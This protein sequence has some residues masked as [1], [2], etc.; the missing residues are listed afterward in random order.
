MNKRFQ[1]SHKWTFAVLLVLLS[2]GII[3][4]QADLKKFGASGVPVFHWDV[5]RAN[6]TNPGQSRIYIYL[7]TA[8]DELTFVREDS[9][10]KASYEV[11]VVI[12]DKDD[13]QVDGKM[14][15]EE[16][17]ADQ[18]GKTNSRRLFSITYEKFDL[19]PGEYKLSIGFTDLETNKTKTDKKKL[20]LKDYSKGELEI[21][22][23][24][25][26]RNLQI[27][28]L[29]V[30]SFMPD[31]S[32]YIIDISRELYGYFEIYNRKA[33]LQNLEI[34]YTIKNAKGK[35]VYKTQYKRR[36]DGER[37]LEYFPISTNS[38][39]QGVYQLKLKVIQGKHKKEVKKI[40]IIRWADMPSTIYDIELAIKQLKY[41]ANKKEWDKLKKASQD[42][43]LIAF[44]DF[45]DKR[46]PSPGTAKNEWMDEYYNRIAF[47]NANF[48]GFR[49]GW[50]SDMGMIYIIFGPPSDIERHPFDSDAKPYEI[51]YYYS[52]NKQFIFMDLT[53]FGEYRLLTK[54]W[55]DWRYLI[56]N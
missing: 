21:S 28:S 39:T 24:A 56:K 10:Y 7:K 32:D 12:K 5:V 2:W 34:Y 27:D 54:S 9:L 50:K 42:E 31:V 51:W 23:L 36:P 35:E 47:A 30:K 14:W 46:D 25:F 1:M 43:K 53:G 41:I 33:N 13:F 20:K 44:K 4:G 15:Q 19:P 29:G 26:V 49:D 17:V 40:F 37:T 16:V 45:W 6:S 3:M 18:Y 38:L 22:D 55:E 52:I 11:S 8:F 48:G